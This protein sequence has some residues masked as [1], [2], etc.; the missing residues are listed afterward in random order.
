MKQNIKMALFTVLVLLPLQRFIVQRFGT[1]DGKR[2]GVHKNPSISYFEQAVS[3]TRY[4]TT[5][6]YFFKSKLR[7]M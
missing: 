6:M 7:I 4:D 2:Y 1:N 5:R 3:N